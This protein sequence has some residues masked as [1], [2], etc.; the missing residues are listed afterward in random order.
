[1]ESEPERRARTALERRVAGL[2]RKV[3]ALEG[4]LS[5]RGRESDGDAKR[6]A[7][8]ADVT[9][10]IAEVV[11]TTEAQVMVLTGRVDIADEEL[12]RIGERF[13]AVE[14]RLPRDP[15]PVEEPRNP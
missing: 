8:L 9:A 13:V 4:V 10:E 7:E 2:E 15:P 3:A 1:M 14:E 5:R 6:T 12:V 11:E